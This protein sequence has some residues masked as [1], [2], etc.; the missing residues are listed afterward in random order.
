MKALLLA[1]GLGTRLRPLTNTIP[2]C[3]VPI[4]GKPLLGYWFDLIFKSTIDSALVN[5]HYLHEM[6]E[7]YI[8]KSPYKSQIETVY[9][10]ELL[11]TAGTLLRNRDFFEAEP[12][13]MVHADN[14]SIF[15]VESFVRAHRHRPENCDITMMTFQTDTPQS[16]G[17]V[18]LNNDGVVVGFHEKVKNPPSNLAN[19]AVYIIESSVIN[20]LE[21]FNEKVSDFSTQVLPEYMGKIF[22]FHNHI[23]HRDIGTMES[24]Q[25]AQEKK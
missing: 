10:N 23:Y 13:L 21:Q 20:F 3:L 4:N 2:K 12:V 24:Y 1:A 11:G 15:D 19:G 6:V 9:E 14:Y 8:L 18:E 25:K 22:T 7:D 17:I 5:L 16:C